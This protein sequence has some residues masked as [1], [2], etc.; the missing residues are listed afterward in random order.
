MTCNQIHSTKKYALVQGHFPYKNHPFWQAHQGVNGWKATHL[1]LSW[2]LISLGNFHTFY[3]TTH[4]IYRGIFF[5]NILFYSIALRT[6]NKMRR[7]GMNPLTNWLHVD[8]ETMI[9]KC[10]LTINLSCGFG[11]KHESWT[12]SF[13]SILGSN[14]SQTLWF[15]C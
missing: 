7:N 9:M 8:I 2:F 6:P 12:S 5:N 14:Y 11:T 4:K 13:W 1:V 3:F 15:Y 10:E